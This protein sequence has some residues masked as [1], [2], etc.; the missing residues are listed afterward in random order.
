LTLEV[1][2]SKSITQDHKSF[3][4]A[5]HRG[6]LTGPPQKEQQEALPLAKRHRYES[7]NCQ[8]ELVLDTFTK[9]KSKLLFG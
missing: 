9:L 4:T 2:Q 3:L 1:R 5:G 8:S 7:E 6:A